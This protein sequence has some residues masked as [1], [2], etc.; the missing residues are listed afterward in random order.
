MAPIKEEDDEENEK[1]ETAL[2]V[3]QSKIMEDNLKKGTDGVKK[4]KEKHLTAV[5]Q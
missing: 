5:I 4:R 2:D 3:F 1:F